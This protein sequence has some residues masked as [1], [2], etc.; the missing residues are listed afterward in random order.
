MCTRGLRS[1]HH[2]PH[3]KKDLPRMISKKISTLSCSKDIF[4]AEDKSSTTSKRN[5]KSEVIWF[6]PPWNDAVA[7]N[8]AGKFLQLIDKHFP[9]N[10]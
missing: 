5:R 9:R 8:L 10:S 7:T 3:I 2:P 6:N 1:N 4:V